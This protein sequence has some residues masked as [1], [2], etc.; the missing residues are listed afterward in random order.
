MLVEPFPQTVRT[1]ESYGLFWP[2]ALSD[3]PAIRTFSDW[4]REGQRV[5]WGALFST[6]RCPSCETTNFFTDDKHYLTY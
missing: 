4:L 5:R 6:Y 3:M 2:R 1:G